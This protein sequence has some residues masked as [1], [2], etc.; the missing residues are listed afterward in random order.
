MISTPEK[1]DISQMPHKLNS[2]KYMHLKKRKTEH[3]YPFTGNSSIQFL[4]FL[5]IDFLEQAMENF[6]ARQYKKTRV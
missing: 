2:T 5:Q 1:S 3:I 6:T 4:F